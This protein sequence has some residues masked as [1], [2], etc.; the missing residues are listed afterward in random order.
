VRS[1]GNSISQGGRFQAEP[2]NNDR[3]LDGKVAEIRGTRILFNPDHPIIRKETDKTDSPRERQVIVACFAVAFE[4]LANECMR[5]LKRL[6]TDHELELSA[7]SNVMAKL[8]ANTDGRVILPLEKISV[9][10]KP[11]RKDNK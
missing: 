5:Y 9:A 10:Q 1:T 11:K 8:R 2:F 3:E 6:P 7:L 4:A